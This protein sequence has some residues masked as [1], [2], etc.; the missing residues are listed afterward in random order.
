MEFVNM[1]RFQNVPTFTRTLN[2]GMLEY[3][4][5]KVSLC[6]VIPTYTISYRINEPN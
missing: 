2:V 3:E 1:L 5:N 6:K 4:Y